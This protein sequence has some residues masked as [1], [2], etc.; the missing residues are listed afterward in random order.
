[1]LRHALSAVP[2]EK[3]H[4]PRRV[5]TKLKDILGKALDQADR[6]LTY[7]LDEYGCRFAIYRARLIGAAPP[8]QTFCFTYRPSSPS[9]TV[10]TCNF[11]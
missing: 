4:T 7:I 11:T 2:G 9:S 3:P 8:A 5:D 1:M 10:I 6:A